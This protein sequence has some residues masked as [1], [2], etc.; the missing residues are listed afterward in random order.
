MHLGPQLID[1][2]FQA[3][4]TTKTKIFDSSAVVLCAVD[5]CT[6]YTF[7]VMREGKEERKKKKK[8]K[9]EEQNR[10]F[11]VQFS[12]LSGEVMELWGYVIHKN[13]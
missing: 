2:S 13:S 11:H 10:N 12:P 1:L 9:K 3:A 4:L 5:L 7:Q 8:K 6:P